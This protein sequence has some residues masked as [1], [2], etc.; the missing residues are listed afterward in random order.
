MPTPELIAEGREKN[1]DLDFLDGQRRVSMARGIER[2][3]AVSPDG[4]KVAYQTDSGFF[5][6]ELVP[7]SK[8]TATKL[9]G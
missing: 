9:G 2:Y 7:V 5:V 1:Y 3:F 8:A 6:R 4:L